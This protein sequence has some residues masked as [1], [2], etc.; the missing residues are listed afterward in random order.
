M[1]F[2]HIYSKC[3]QCLDNKKWLC[4]FITLVFVWYMYLL[5]YG[6][7][8]QSFCLVFL[9]K[10]N[11]NPTGLNHWKL[12]ITKYT[13]RKKSIIQGNQSRGSRDIF[14]KSLHLR[15]GQQWLL[16]IFL[17]LFEAFYFFILS[18]LYFFFSIFAPSSIKLAKCQ[19]ILYTNS[20]YKYRL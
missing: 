14:Q 20:I 9:I 18:I 16:Y 6:H 11:K 10:F 17:S 19:T 15:N 13:T 5:V 7:K 2:I 1:W 8:T 4:T 3:V 12:S